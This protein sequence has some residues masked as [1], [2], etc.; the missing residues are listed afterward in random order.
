VTPARATA[1]ASAVLVLSVVVAPALV[2]RAAA[3][4]GGAGVVAG[5]DLVA[6]G[7]AVGAVAAV[8]AWRALTTPT[9]AAPTD[10]WIAALTGFAVLAAG[11]TALPTA[12][13]YAVSGVARDSVLVPGLWGGALAVAVLGAE[14][15]RRRLLRWL[16]AAPAA[17][18]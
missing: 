4:R 9:D 16:L 12:A 3:D 13:L 1:A 18:R 17:P 8:L 15:A 5:T 6:A 7:S 10:R 11:A 14:A 2:V